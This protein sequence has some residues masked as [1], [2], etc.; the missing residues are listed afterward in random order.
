MSDLVI[1]HGGEQVQLLEPISKEARTNDLRDVS[2][3]ILI[4][5][6]L[7]A[8]KREDTP[9]AHRI[10]RKAQ[11]FA[12]MLNQ[13]SVTVD[14]FLLAFATDPEGR[15]RA[16]KRGI[17]MAKP[18]RELLEA[19]PYATPNEEVVDNLPLSEGVV[20][21]M[22]HARARASDREEG[23]DLI[24]VD[25][26]LESVLALPTPPRA[27]TPLGMLQS[28]EKLAKATRARGSA[29]ASAAAVLAVTALV[30]AA[31]GAAA[32]L[33]GKGALGWNLLVGWLG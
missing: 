27:R 30:A 26:L 23:L 3:P 32:F 6:E 5:K 2:L 16:D 19:M 20:R 29:G 11:Q 31:V 15:K 13:G 21:I 9:P 18:F 28:Q 1:E 33:A 22:D 7:V 17:D 8:E 12:A 4:I 24:S 14:A 25:D 10:M